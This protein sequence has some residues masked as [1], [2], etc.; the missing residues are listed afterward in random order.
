M[1]SHGTC[2]VSKWQLPVVDHAVSTNSGSLG[3][4][5]IWMGF[6]SSLLQLSWWQCWLAVRLRMRWCAWLSELQVA[7]SRTLWSLNVPLRA[8][9]RNLQCFLANG[10]Q[11][12]KV[13]IKV[14][15][16]N[17]HCYCK[18]NNNCRSEGRWGHRIKDHISGTG[19][20]PPANLLLISVGMELRSSY[21]RER[22][23]VLR[24]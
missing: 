17:V 22:E 2:V 23:R 6:V 8:N 24:V 14:L 9:S 16:Y 7:S 18:W 19:C 15:V 12:R 3:K 20:I 5:S 10:H 4:P 11:G 13:H 21:Q 1:D